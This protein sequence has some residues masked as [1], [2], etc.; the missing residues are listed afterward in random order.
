METIKKG[1][2]ENVMLQ[3]VHQIVLHLAGNSGLDSTLLKKSEGLF[4]SLSERLWSRTRIP[5]VKTLGKSFESISC[6]KKL[7]DGTNM[8]MS[9]MVD[10]VTRLD[11]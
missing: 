9:S 3:Y 2:Y 6:K 11:L 10:E 4:D 8:A 5:A 7:A 1:L